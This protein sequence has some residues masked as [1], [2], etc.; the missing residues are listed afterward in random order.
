MGAD[1]GNK[2]QKVFLKSGS[3]VRMLYDLEKVAYTYY[4]Y[5][6]IYIVGLG[7]RV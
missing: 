6:C 3:P 2:S 1:H 5:I 7:F 4:M